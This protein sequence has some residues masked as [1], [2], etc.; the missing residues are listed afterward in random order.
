MKQSVLCV[1][2]AN[3][4]SGYLSNSSIFSTPVPQG[5]HVPSSRTIP[6]PRVN[7]EN[8]FASQ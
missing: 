1:C 6:N 5:N 2:V 8:E 3:L 7:F 4:Y